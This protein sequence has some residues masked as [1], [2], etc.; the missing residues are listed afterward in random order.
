MGSAYTPGLT[1]SGYTKIRKSRQLPINGQVLVKTGDTVEPN[2]I[3]ARA[4][5][6]GMIQTVK[7]TEL[8]GVEPKE[9]RNF[10]LVKEGDPITKGQLLGE[11]KGF[12]GLFKTSVAAPVDGTFE[13]LFPI[14]G[15]MALREPPIPID[16]TAYINGTVVAV[17]DGRGAEIEAEGAL[18]QG[19]FGVGGERSGEIITVVSGPD[20]I[21]DSGH[22]KP[23]HKG[24]IV[25]GGAGVTAAG[26]RSAVQA[27]AVGI[28]CGG[29]KDSDLVQFLGFDIGVAI[30]GQEDIPLSI[31]LTEG[32]GM[33]AMA[34]RTFYLLKSLDG[35]H[36]SINGATQI[37]AGVIRPEIV[38]PLTEKMT[39][40]PAE[41]TD[42]TL[43][44]GTPI[45]VI[46]EP[47][48][49]SLA[50]VTQLPHEL[51]EIESGA[52]VRILYAKLQSGEEVRVPRANV[53]I[54]AG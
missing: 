12:L 44:I 11:T 54:L 36:A 52:E 21:L 8:L 35:K 28:V 15:H 14:S 48:F 41:E 47:Y 53:E 16:K 32:F 2:T 40:K 19:I 22:F 10:L 51:V 33:L 18:I 3:I 31:I 43:D 34:E 20:E 37:R 25:V 42:Q 45:R 46:R 5:L 50:T 38:V 49:G 24:K 29:I 27:G 39:E 1:V 23:E 30:T 17:Q 7:F 4:E 9:V 6:P 13:A 26:I